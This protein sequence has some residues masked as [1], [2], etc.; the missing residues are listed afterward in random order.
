M[1]P[2]LDNI[3]IAL[4]LRLFALGHRIAARRQDIAEMASLATET[5]IRVIRL[6]A[7]QGLMR[8]VQGKIFID[9]ITPLQKLLRN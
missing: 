4:T 7:D 6:F 1:N 5:T 9:S 3:G 2:L 8:I